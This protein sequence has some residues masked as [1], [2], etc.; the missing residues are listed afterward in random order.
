MNKQ[1]LIDTARKMW[2]ED[3]SFLVILDYIDEAI[4]ELVTA[5]VNE[6]VAIDRVEGPR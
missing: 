2:E 4:D 1:Q 5:A 6:A 3:I